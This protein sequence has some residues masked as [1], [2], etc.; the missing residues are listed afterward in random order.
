MH[1]IVH[2]VASLGMDLGQGP[3]SQEQQR[4]LKI[5]ARSPQAAAHC[6]WAV[7]VHPHTYAGDSAINTV[8]I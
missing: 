6:P 8:N 5:G 2:Q 7:G 3:V 4:G 1:Y